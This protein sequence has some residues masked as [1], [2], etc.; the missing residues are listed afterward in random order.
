M[1]PK[2]TSCGKLWRIWSPSSAPWHPSCAKVGNRPDKSMSNS[3]SN[4][5]LTSESLIDTASDSELSL[6]TAS[7]VKGDET[8]WATFYESSRLRLLGYLSRTW[9]VESPATSTTSSRKPS[10]ARCATCASFTTKLRSGAGSPSLPVPRLPTTDG[11]AH[12]GEVSFGAGD[13]RRNSAPFPAPLTSSLHC[14]T[15]RSPSSMKTRALAPSVEKPP[16]P[17][18]SSPWTRNSSPLSWTTAPC[19]SSTPTAASSCF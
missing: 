5:A 17:T 14:S 13:S 4:P 6:F 18:K 8:A 15:R 2:L 19:S 3:V 16:R 11:A 10:S 1:P 12:V 9:R 7:L